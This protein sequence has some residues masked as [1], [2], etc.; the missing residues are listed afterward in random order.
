MQQTINTLVGTSWTGTMSNYLG[1][2]QN[3]TIEFDSNSGTII[4]PGSLTFDYTQ[5]ID[6]GKVT[7][8]RATPS[9]QDFVLGG[10]GLLHGNQ[11]SGTWNIQGVIWGFQV[12]LN[13]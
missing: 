10:V 9:T 6:D 8:F 4:L 12:T 11:I 7:S 3:C 1:H 13:S 2:P 5:A